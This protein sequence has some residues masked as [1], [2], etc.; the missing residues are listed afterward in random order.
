MTSAPVSELRK[1]IDGSLVMK[2]ETA[3]ISQYLALGFKLPEIF[4]AE[5]R[6]GKTDI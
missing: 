6:D 1:T 3:D 2:L 5:G 4:K